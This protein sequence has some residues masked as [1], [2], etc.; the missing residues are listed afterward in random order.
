MSNHVSSQVYK[1]K[2]GS[3][4]RKAVMVLLADKAS[5]DGGG[6]W[7]SKQRMAD[8]LDMSKQTVINTIKAFISEGLLEE[9]GRRKCP[10]G[11][12]ILYAINL[13]AIAEL[14]FNKSHDD[15][16][17]SLTGQ[18]ALPVNVDDLTGQRALPDQSTSLTQTP[19][20]HPEP[21]N[22]CSSGDEPAF[23]C[24][25]VA[26]HWNANAARWGK[27]TIRKFDDDR[28]KLVRARI[29]EHG[30]EG[31]QEMFANLG[32]SDFL[33]KSKGLQFDWFMGKKN[34]LKVLEGNYNG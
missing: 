27:S 14:P 23:T 21:S 10:N 17:T 11:F 24:K 31:F 1:R 22:T 2:L 16:S 15:Q 29:A 25:H 7:A 20:N 6:I 4:T 18:R 19:L 28:R 26:E 34:F 13:D 33:Q 12:T 3:A 9:V 5:D 30:L 8:E 32:A